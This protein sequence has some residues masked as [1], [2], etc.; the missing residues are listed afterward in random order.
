MSDEYFLIKGPPRKDSCIMCDYHACT[1]DGRSYC[2]LSLGIVHQTGENDMPRPSEKCLAARAAAKTLRAL[3][4]QALDVVEGSME[5]N[6]ACFA[7][8]VL[9]S[10]E[11]FGDE[12]VASTSMV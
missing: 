8:V 5:P 7:K 9:E 2:E 1:Q 10:L 11:V 6:T 4:H 3:A 12:D